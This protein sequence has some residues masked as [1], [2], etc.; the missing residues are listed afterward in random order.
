MQHCV[1]ADNPS[2]NALLPPP[3]IVR[4]MKTFRARV[5]NSGSCPVVL[6]GGTVDA[7][8]RPS[9]WKQ[10][11][12]NC[13]T[14]TPTTAALC[15]SLS[16]QLTGLVPSSKCGGF[17]SQSACIA[18]DTCDWD[19]WQ[20]KPLC[21]NQWNATDRTT[22]EDNDKCVWD[23]V[24]NTCNNPDGSV[25][26]DCRSDGIT[27]NCAAQLNRVCGSPPCVAPCMEKDGQCT[28]WT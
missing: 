15:S 27:A 8:S 16:A 7:V 12:T 5:E 17:D 23:R 14:S 28:G 2:D 1:I 10:S 11:V 21:C 20:C 13:P 4:D 19:G 18:E 26:T 24:R 6:D 22:C 3:S 25:C 9:F